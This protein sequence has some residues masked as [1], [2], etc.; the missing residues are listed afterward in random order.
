MNEQPRFNPDKLRLLRES[1]AMSQSEVARELKIT[2]AAFSK[3]ESGDL[4]PSEEMKAKIAEFFGYPIPYF[5]EE[6]DE[7]PSGLIFHRKRSALPAKERARIEAEARLRLLDVVKMLKITGRRSNLIDR[8]GR[9]P[10]EMA[11]A[12][13]KHWRATVSKP[14]ENLVALLEKNDVLVLSFDFGSDKLD[15]F[16]LCV[17]EDFVC[18]ALNDATVFTPDR[19]RF[20]LAHELGHA[21][22][23]REQFPDDDAEKEANEFASEFLAPAS[24]FKKDVKKPITLPLLGDLKRKWKISMAAALYRANTTGRVNDREYRRLCITLSSM[25][26]RKREPLCGLAPENPNLLL[27]IV[28]ECR[29]KIGENALLD[30]L[31]LNERVFRLRYLLPNSKEVDVSP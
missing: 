30:Y 9:S 11:K 28:E 10:I 17:T 2:Q 29:Q 22:L 13:R 24:A 21:L 7:I 15:G 6:T 27:A 26:F 1:R 3:L 18:I 5:Y 20:T 31:S 19:R 23:H 8:E 12:L 16:F 4:A 14:I 25:G